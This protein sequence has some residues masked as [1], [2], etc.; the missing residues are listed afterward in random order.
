MGVLMR[1]CSTERKIAK[2]SEQALAK[3]FALR[4]GVHIDFHANLHFN[5][6]RCFPGH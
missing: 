6:L 5:N 3:L 1:G 4:A 2:T